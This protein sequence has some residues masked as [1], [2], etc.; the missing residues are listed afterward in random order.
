MRLS[1][2]V[3]AFLGVHTAVRIGTKVKPTQRK[4]IE[5]NC[6]GDGRRAEERLPAEGQ[7]HF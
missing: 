5:Y 6:A 3:R 1:D 2:C 4:E 7:C